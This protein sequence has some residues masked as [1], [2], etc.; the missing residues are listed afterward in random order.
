MSKIDVWEPHLPI[1]VEFE[2]INL[3]VGP[4]LEV[5]AVEIEVAYLVGGHI[6]DARRCA[7]IGTRSNCV[8]S[9]G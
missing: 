5:Y 8:R 2:P 1:G 9:P 3:V 4:G 7:P 6:M